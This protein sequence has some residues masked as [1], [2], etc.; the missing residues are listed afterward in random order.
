MELEREKQ[1]QIYQ[2]CWLGF[3]LLAV[4]LVLAT[5]STLL[6]LARFFHV[7]GLALINLSWLWWIDIPIIWGTLA[8]SYMLW[9]RWSD[10]GWIRRSGLLVVMCM[11]DVV[12]W[13]LDQGYELGPGRAAGLEQH[14]WLCMHIGQALGW[15][16]FA[17][18]ASL[19][20]DFLAHLG[21]E[22]A[23]DAGKAT[24][25]LAATGAGVW[26]F[27]FLLQTDWHRWP[28]Q[29]RQPFFTADTLLLFMGSKIIWAIALIQVTAL[30]IAAAGQA[31]SV[32]TEMNR[33]DREDDLFRSPSDTAAGLLSTLKGDS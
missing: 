27:L 5:A 28:L 20:A 2:L 6:G 7:P 33:E 8:G 23:P 32:L 15:A 30:T 19:S 10:T 29:H 31:S 26:M 13:L 21:L 25:S 12:L 16:E 18:L 22:N 1:R 17:L 3:S 4:S 11:A 9:G 24:R 14:E